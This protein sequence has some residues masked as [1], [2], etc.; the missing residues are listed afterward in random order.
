[1]KLLAALFGAAPVTGALAVFLDSPVL[2]LLS[3]GMMAGVIIGLLAFGLRT[4][5]QCNFAMPF[6]ITLAAALGGA[7][8]G[9]LAVTVGERGDA[10]GLM[11]WGIMLIVSVIVGAS[12]LAAR[13]AQRR[14]R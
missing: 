13:P 10:P 12:T 7:A 5:R 2:V 14:G 3:V 8:L 11:L 4:A 1:M 6:L 9:V